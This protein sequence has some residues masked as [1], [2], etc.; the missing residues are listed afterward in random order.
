MNSRHYMSRRENRRA[1]FRSHAGPS[2]PFLALSHPHFLPLTPTG[3]LVACAETGRAVAA[4]ALAK[5]LLAPEY[6]RAF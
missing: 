1:C 5:P 6:L 3:T 2:H 4:R